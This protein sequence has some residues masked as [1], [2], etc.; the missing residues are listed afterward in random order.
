MHTRF[1]FALHP[2]PRFPAQSDH[3]RS[4]LLQVFPDLESASLQREMFIS[5]SRRASTTSALSGTAAATATAAGTSTT[6]GASTVSEP[7]TLHSG[8]ELR[9]KSHLPTPS[10][11]GSLNARRTSLLTAA[12][13]ASFTPAS[14]STLSGLNLGSRMLPFSRATVVPTEHSGST[15]SPSSLVIST[16]SSSSAAAA[17][18]VAKPRA[19]VMRPASFT[20]GAGMQ[21]RRGSTLADMEDM[22]VQHNNNNNNK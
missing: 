1:S 16:S 22:E 5:A 20:A 12:S 10:P 7:G 4:L 3:L 14:T 6:I 19:S 18:S 8:E 9:E 13:F 21:F 17:L 15:S 11:P 2:F